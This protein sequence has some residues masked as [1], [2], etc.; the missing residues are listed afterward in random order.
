MTR[1]YNDH[2][3]Y[4]EVN[5]ITSEYYEYSFY[6]NKKRR[7]QKNKISTYIYWPNQRLKE[8]DGFVSKRILHRL[9]AWQMHTFGSSYMHDYGKA[10]RIVS[11]Y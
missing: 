1:K 9:I 3:F 5:L 7:E 10:K 11:I 6:K 2:S 4:T 8:S